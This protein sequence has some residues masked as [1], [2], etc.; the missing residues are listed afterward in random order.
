VRASHY[1]GFDFDKTGFGRLSGVL[2]PNILSEEVWD[3][4]RGL[5]L[6]NPKFGF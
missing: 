2:V 3:V 6:S 1:F 5:V 4:S